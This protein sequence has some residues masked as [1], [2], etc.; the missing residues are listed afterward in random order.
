MESFG[1]FLVGVGDDTA[2]IREDEVKEEKPKEENSP[3][4]FSSLFGM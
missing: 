3:M 2:P 4:D 1:T